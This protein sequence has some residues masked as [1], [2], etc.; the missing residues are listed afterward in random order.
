MA[1]TTFKIE[2]AN[3]NIEEVVKDGMFTPAQLIQAYEANKAA[4]SGTVLSMT[5]NNKTVTVYEVKAFINSG[6]DSKR[7]KM[8]NTDL[9]HEMYSSKGRYYG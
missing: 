4:K 1:T 5:I 3:G 7:Q 9:S 8:T 2:R 6:K